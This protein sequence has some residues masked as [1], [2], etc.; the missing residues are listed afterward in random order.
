MKVHHVWRR[1][2]LSG[3]LLWVLMS[4]WVYVVSEQFGNLHLLPGSPLLN[5]KVFRFLLCKGSSILGEL[6]QGQLG[7]A[8]AEN[9]CT[10]E[11]EV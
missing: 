5:W 10:A 1:S 6:S 11:R 3:A 4:T 7:W 2:P 8:V 9:L